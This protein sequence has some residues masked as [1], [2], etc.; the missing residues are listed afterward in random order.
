MK[1]T[2]IRASCQLGYETGY[3]KIIRLPSNVAITPALLVYFLIIYQSSTY[4]FNYYHS[5]KR[6]FNNVSYYPI[7]SKIGIVDNF[8]NKKWISKKRR[9]S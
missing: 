1:E 4:F 9:E 2:A 5:M 7:D 8:V 6:T 3:G